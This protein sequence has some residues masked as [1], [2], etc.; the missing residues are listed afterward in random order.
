MDTVSSG[1]TERAAMVE[2]VRERY[3]LAA[4]QAQSGGGDCGSS[5]GSG[6]AVSADLYATDQLAGLQRR[7]R[8][9]HLAAAIPPRS[10]T[11]RKDRRC[12]TL[13]LVA[14]LTCSSLPSALGLV[15]SCT[16]ST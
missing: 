8:L 14:G 2:R 11:C 9:P 4:Q 16:A 3:A 5:G 7:R 6:D 13:G 15:G 12:L 1:A 10:S